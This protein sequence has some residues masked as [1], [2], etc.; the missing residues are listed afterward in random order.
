MTPD[1][2]L[3]RYQRQLRCAHLGEDGQRALMASTVL[4]VGVGGLGSWT[5]E[6]LARSGVGMLRLVDFDRIEVENIHRQ[7]FYTEAD[8][9]RLKVDAAAERMAAI[10]SSVRVET[11]A[12]RVSAQNIA[13]LAGGV[14]L[15]IDG[16]DNFATRFVLNDYAVQQS[17]PWIF[18]GALASEAQT[19]TIVPGRTPCLRCIYDGPP[20]AG[21][22]PSNA[23]FGILPS[24]VMTMC[25][26]QAT[27]AMKILAGRL[28]DISPYLLKVDL[29]TNTIQRVDI[30]AAAA[31]GDCPCCGRRQFD[32]L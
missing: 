15:I 9:G 17:V 19:M 20:A 4:V 31:G 26:L 12:E 13:A 21:Q 22:E 16:T 28:D 1:D 5:A 14:D 6:I 29:W 2:P 25:G 7:A 23:E 3:A 11:A 8:E 24:L 32:H 18:T 30:S 10:N 27:E